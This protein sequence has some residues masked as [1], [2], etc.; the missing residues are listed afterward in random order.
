[1]VAPMFNTVLSEQSSLLLFVLTAITLLASPGPATLA[2]AASGAKYGLKSSL[3]FFAG[4]IGGLSIALIAV[5]SGLFLIIQSIPIVST[6]LTIVSAIYILFLAYSI[7]KTPPSSTRQNDST[8]SPAHGLIIGVTNIKAYAVF[9][10]LFSSYPLGIESHWELLIK[11][12]ICLGVSTTFDFLWLLC[13]NHLSRYFLHPY[14]GR[15][16]NGGFAVFLVAAVAWSF[17]L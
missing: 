16:L 1:M 8:P 13:G 3:G 7:A 5:A 11:I 12:S 4:I 6:G 10:A 2:L 14:W 15:L 9:A 17:F